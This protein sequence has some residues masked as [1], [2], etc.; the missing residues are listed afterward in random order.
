MKYSRAAARV[1]APSK[2][3]PT[4]LTVGVPVVGGTTSSYQR[5]ASRRSALPVDETPVGS[6]EMAWAVHRRPLRMCAAMSRSSS[7]SRLPFVPFVSP[8]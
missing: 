6:T 7:A 5:T 8:R 4:W 3:V 2:I 1:A